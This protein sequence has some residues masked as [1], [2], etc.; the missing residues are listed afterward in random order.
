MGRTVR[1]A[2]DPL[3]LGF[4]A[5]LEDDL[6]LAACD[7]RCSMAHVR[8]LSGGGIIGDATAKQ[9]TD[10]LAA[11]E[12][13]IARGTFAAHARASGAEDIHGAIDA[14]V[15][16]LAGE[17]GE[18]LHAARSRNDQVAT[19][20]R[21]YMAQQTALAR[22]ACAEGLEALLVHADGAMA[23]QTMVPVMTHWQPAQP[24]LLAF[25]LAAAGQSIARA[26]ANCARAGGGV[27]DE[28]PL[29]SA[30]LCGSTLPLDREAACAALGFTRLSINALD[31]VGS[32]DAVL[33][34]AHA[35]VTALVACSRICEEL[36]VW[37]N[38]LFGFASLSD[39]ASTGSS[40]M[41]QKRNPDP[42]ELVRG[43]SARMIGV[44]AGALASTSGLALSYHR[45]LQQTKAA[46]LQIAREGVA[47][48]QAFAAALAHVRFNDEAMNAAAGMGFAVATDIA[49][50]LVGAGIPARRA[51]AAVGTA[52]ARAEREG[53]N[54]ESADIVQI[55]DSLGIPAIDAP[56]TPAQSV[57]HKCTDGSTGPAA[58]QSQ[59][60]YLRSQLSALQDA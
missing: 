17:P 39:A 21:L 38:P 56:L 53:R 5:S 45:D 3:L 60:L 25:W 4:G 44:Y 52:V 57:R 54:L 6:V 24:A 33:D 7:V 41:P 2:A 18:M 35:I 20:L 31:A 10:A 34:A 58:V 16:D 28:M 32:R 55:C 12:S 30:A 50:A 49:D 42:L 15:R 46:V 40:L 11:V 29:G 13:E 43:L 14:R 22:A 51:H 23:T 36:T 37:C 59:L 47:G 26:G 19:T 8:A 48:L 27:M 1:A 9:I